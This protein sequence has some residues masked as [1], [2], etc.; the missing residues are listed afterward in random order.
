MRT[1]KKSL[2]FFLLL[3]TVTP[4]WAALTPCTGRLIN[5]VTDICWDCLLPITIG[6]TPIMTGTNPDTR[7]PTDTFCTCD[8]DL[9]PKIGVSVGYWEPME[10]IDVTRSPYC[11][12]NLGGWKLWDSP[13]DGAVAVDDP[14]QNTGFFYVHAIH[15]PIMQ[16]LGVPTPSCADADKITLTYVSELDPTWADETLALTLFP[17][18]L[19]F[20]NLPMQAACA[21]DAAA[22][23]VS[24]PLD[25]LFWCAGAQGTMYPLTGTVGEYIGGVQGSVLLSERLIFK[26]HRLGLMP[27][28]SPDHLC[29]QSIE[30]TLPKSRYRYQMMNPT[31]TVTPTGCQPFGRTTMLWGSLL[32]S[33]ISPENYGYLVWRK[34]NCC[35]L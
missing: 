13:N 1:V 3:L 34:R 31:P 32:E 26:L 8:D 16:F 17:E 10:L 12:V 24:L 11:L 27:D 33:P 9:F 22:A 7:N 29:T 5:P 18:T 20:N 35:W 23:A 15:F 14:N 4:G 30:P 19:L 6:S 2:F 25:S 28:S 21:A